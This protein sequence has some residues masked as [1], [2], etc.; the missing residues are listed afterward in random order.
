MFGVS[1]LRL[2]LYAAAV[3][4]LVAA[5]LWR[6]DQGESAPPPAPAAAALSA[7]PDLALAQPGGVA[8]PARDLFRNPGLAPEAPPPPPPPPPEPEP[9]VQT[10]QFDPMAEQ[11]DFAEAVLDEYRVVG[12]LRVGADMVATMARGGV[13]VTVKE[14]ER[15]P[16]GFVA[17]RVAIDHIVLAHDELGVERRFQEG[18]VDGD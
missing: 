4:A 13:V 14:G 17:R 5:N 11:I 1:R 12:I 9:V 3:I 2:S 7:L 10:P 8:P 18:V 16:E 15:L 6:L